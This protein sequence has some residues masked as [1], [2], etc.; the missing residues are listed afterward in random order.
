M[1]GHGF[2]EVVGENMGGFETLL[3][4][5]G[6]VVAIAVCRIDGLQRLLRKEDHDVY[7]T[8]DDSF[9]AHNCRSDH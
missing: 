3:L 9:V 1:F 2:S 4:L 8:H 6:S 5:A 7:A